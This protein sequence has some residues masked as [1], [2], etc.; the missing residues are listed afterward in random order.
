MD[1]LRDAFGP[2]LAL[3][4]DLALLLMGAAAWL[5]SRDR[6]EFKQRLDKHGE[7]IG[8]LEQTVPTR[9]EVTGAFDR[10]RDEVR[11]DIASLKADIN[12]RLDTI[13]GIMRKH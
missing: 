1:A 6:A 2:L 10:L 8:D 11:E 3:L 12:D 9:T 5:Y 13:I 7:R 4:R